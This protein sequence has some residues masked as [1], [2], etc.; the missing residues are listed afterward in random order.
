MVKQQFI[1]MY[2]FMYVG[3]DYESG[4][5]NITIP[6]GES[7]VPFNISIID[8]DVFEGNESFC[9]TVDRS[10]LPSRIIVSA[11][12]LS[13]ATIVDDDGGKLIAM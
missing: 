9:I 7:L 3:D 6:A 5:F 8:D 12:C 4:P 11:V 1:F 13:I 10:S 2:Y